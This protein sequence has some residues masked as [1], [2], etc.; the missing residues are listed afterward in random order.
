MR[1][2]K[3]GWVVFGSLLFV[4]SACSGD[5]GGAE[6]DDGGR[7]GGAGTG[8]S[9]SG[10]GGSSASGG[11]GGSAAGTGGV[12]GKGGTGGSAAGTGGVSGK[13]GTGGTGGSGPMPCDTSDFEW[14]DPGC[15]EDSL[16]TF[17]NPI[18]SNLYKCLIG[19]A[20][21]GLSCDSCLE[22]VSVGYAMNDIC[23][24]GITEAELNEICLD[25]ALDYAQ[26]YPECSPEQ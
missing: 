16:R 4:V 2:T 15:P 6:D 3:C 7:G 21:A 14:E 13:G 20:C 26:S 8:G 22:T 11:S 17:G 19:S 25:Y 18:C 24:Q 5:G 9:A 23:V 10:S 12:S 1:G